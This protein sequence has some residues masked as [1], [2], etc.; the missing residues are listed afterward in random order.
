MKKRLLIVTVVLAAVAVVL[1]LK[2]ENRHELSPA[3]SVAEKVSDE[4]GNG[5]TVLLFADPREAEESCGCGEIIQMVRDL[6]GVSGVH[7]RE[8][9]TRSPS[10]D[11]RQYGVRTSPV[12]I[13]LDASG[14][15]R[16]RFEGESSPT[17]TSLLSA[18]D[19]LHH[20][21]TPS[22]EVATP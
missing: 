4:E 16:E 18:L 10:P 14:R 5:A 9:D 8:I 1:W 17:I 3:P 12:V 11:A 13:I 19:T 22:G 2:W 20:S 15:E 21:S 7:F 6:R